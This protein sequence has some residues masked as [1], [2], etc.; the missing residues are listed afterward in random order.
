MAGMELSPFWLQRLH[1]TAL[2]TIEMT[3]HSFILK[4]IYCTL[5]GL[6]VPS[7]SFL[8]SAQKANKSNYQ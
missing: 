3:L 6:F 5:G 7:Y 2:R 1:V 4:Y 8:N